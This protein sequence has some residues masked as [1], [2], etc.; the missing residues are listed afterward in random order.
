MTRPTFWDLEAVADYIGVT[1]ASARTYHGRSQINRKNGTPRPGD[2]PEPDERFG[3]SPVWRPETI[4]TWYTQQR[5][6]R[7]AG[8]GRPKLVPLR[9]R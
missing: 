2:F 5:P 8:G 6:G 9:P 4:I 7:G 1:Y 3:R